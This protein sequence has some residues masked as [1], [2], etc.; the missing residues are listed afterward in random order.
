[1]KE[2]DSMIM[3]M[4]IIVW[5]G[6]GVLLMVMVGRPLFLAVGCQAPKVGCQCS[7]KE[8]GFDKVQTPD[9][10]HVL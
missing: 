3:V 7:K 5:V 4:V 2:L 10:I 6:M 1:M 9:K 8:E